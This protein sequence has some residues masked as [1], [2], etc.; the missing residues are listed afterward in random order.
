MNVREEGICPH[1]GT[2]MCQEVTASCQNLQGYVLGRLQFLTDSSGEVTVASSIRECQRFRETST[3]VKFFAFPGYGKYF[4][5]GL[6]EDLDY[7]D[8]WCLG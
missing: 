8:S 2:E 7:K 5:V 1:V 4:K 6:V 3:P